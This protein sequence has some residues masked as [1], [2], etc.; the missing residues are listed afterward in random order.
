M[1]Y[2]K[3][4]FLA[5][6]SFALFACDT[7]SSV[8]NKAPGSRKLDASKGCFN[9]S[10]LMAGNIVG[11]TRVNVGD[12]DQKV[13]VLMIGAKSESLVFCTANA[14]G[15]RVLLTAAHCIDTTVAKYSIALYPSIT[16]ESGF[17]AQRNLVAVQ[18]VVRNGGYDESLEIQDR[19]DDIALIFL[20]DDLP[21][22]YPI[23]KLANPDDLRDSDMYLYGYG[24]IGGDQGGTGMLRRATLLNSGIKILAAS[25]KVEIDQSKGT[26]ICQGDSG[27][28]GFIKVGDDLQILGV[29][30]Y[31]FKRS[32]EDDL[33]GGKGV[34]TMA[35]AYKV[36]IDEEIEKNGTID[37]A[38]R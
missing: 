24:R 34:Q 14:I 32:S 33:C 27:G 20:K 12:A 22:D 1:S 28:A 11:G 5:V 25:K 26:G 8:N 36:W 3:I 13:A 16:C 18:T 2:L 29:N 7:G 31:V 6:F 15:R 4:T 35:Y 17:K 37:S 21:A 23:F 9:E 19:Q 10:D 30:S 38:T